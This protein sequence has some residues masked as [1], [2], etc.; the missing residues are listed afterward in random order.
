MLDNAIVAVAFIS[1]AAAVGATV[2][3]IMYGDFKA[4]KTIVISS[5]VLFGCAAVAASLL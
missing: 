1:M 4:R 2:G 3:R 5:A